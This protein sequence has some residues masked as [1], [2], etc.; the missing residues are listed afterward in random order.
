MKL[1]CPLSFESAWNLEI[2]LLCQLDQGSTLLCPCPYCELKMKAELSWSSLSVYDPWL[3]YLHLSII[4]LIIEHDSPSVVAS[5]MTTSRSK[6]SRFLSFTSYA[7]S[8]GAST[9]SSLL[10]FSP[11]P[12][13]RTPFSLV[14]L[15]MASYLSPGHRMVHVCKIQKLEVSLLPN[16]G[17]TF[18]I[19]EKMDKS[20]KRLEFSDLTLLAAMIL[21][22]FANLLVISRGFVYLDSSHTSFIYSQIP[23]AQGTPGMVADFS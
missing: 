11:L 10:L 6:S 16:T 1:V 5:S 17:T 15:H 18:F 4:K 23:F 7:S 12:I 8:S 3:F 22:S 21:A 14:S 2:R 19:T 20:L 13:H 9:S